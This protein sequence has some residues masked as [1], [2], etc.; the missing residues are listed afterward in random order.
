MLQLLLSPANAP[1]QAHFQQHRAKLR[2]LAAAAV[3]AAEE[4]CMANVRSHGD[5]CPTDDALLDKVSRAAYAASA[6][7]GLTPQ[8]QRRLSML[9]KSSVVAC[10]PAV[11][12]LFVVCILATIFP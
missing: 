4:A 3:V 2:K 8:V 12:F 7:E 1:M 5:L 11:K 6:V 9:L 10:T